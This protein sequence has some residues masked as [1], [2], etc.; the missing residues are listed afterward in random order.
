MCEVVLDFLRSEA[1]AAKVHGRLNFLCVN[2]LHRE[3]EPCPGPV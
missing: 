1:Y 2:R 3:V